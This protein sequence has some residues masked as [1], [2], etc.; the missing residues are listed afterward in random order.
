MA[1]RSAEEDRMGL[2]PEEIEAHYL[3]S[4]EALRL[5]GS[6]RGELERLRTQKIL[7]QYLPQPP[8][9]I[10]D[11]GGAAGV[12][13]FRLAKEGYQVH[14]IDPVELHLEQA[15]SYSAD[16]GVILASVARGDARQLDIPSGS[17]D[18]VLLLGPLYHLTEY[19]DRLQALRE[20]R[21][22]LKIGGV[23]LAAAV[24]RFASLLDGL[25]TGNFRNAEFREI[26]AADLASGQHR[27]PTNNPFYFT[28]AYFH[29]PED[30]AAEVR[31][32]G[33][34]EVQMLAVE[35][36]AWCT[37][38]FH[39]VW[40][41]SAQRQSL[42]EYLALIEREPSVLGASAHFIAVAHSSS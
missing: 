36:P 16:S 11:V 4:G 33:F 37:A 19:A 26:V 40:D 7:G 23:L 27:N 18:G 6:Q 28:T 32:A 21:R 39:E 12:Y 20:A 15:K 17:A 8:A 22:I 3:G 9:T 10:V 34:S 30:L 35:G 42:M 5:S 38:L 25:S 41:D 14:L 24:S 29:R 2:I 1:E 13:A 31:D